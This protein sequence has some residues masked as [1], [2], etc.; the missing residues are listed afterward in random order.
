MAYLFL[1]LALTS[2]VSAART[3][4]RVVAVVNEDIVL[5]S[6][7]DQIALAQV[8]GNLNLS[9]PEA[10]KQ[11][12]ELR[13]KSL[14]SLIDSALMRQAATELKL[15]A[16]TEEVDRALQD[17]KERNKLDDA[18]FDEALKQQ[19]YTRESFRRDLKKQIVELKVINTQ[20]RSSINIGDDEVRAFYNQNAAKMSGDAEAHLR[21]ILIACDPTAPAAEVEQKRAKAAKIMEQARKGTS[22]EELAKKFSDDSL[23]K[24]VGGDLG[25]VPKGMLVDELDA[26][27]TTMAPGDIRGPVRTPRGFHILQLVERKSGNL[28][29]FEESKDQIRRTLQDQQTEKAMTRWLRELR[30][31]AHIEMKL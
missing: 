19:G 24:E 25:T 16:T 30:K 17:L 13:K 1:A 15:T 12:D 3:V 14:D 18:T 5:D 22:F 11:F 28:R 7:V 2:G 21:M 4:D 9:S 29:S 8:R 10:K 23:T 6:E 31:K 26:A 27:V 20:V